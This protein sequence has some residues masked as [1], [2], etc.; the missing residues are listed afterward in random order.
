M[1]HS[2]SASYLRSH[3]KRSGLTLK[4]VA[5]LL[6]YSHGGEISR[7]ERLSSF[8][9]FKIALRY[10]ALYRT[11]VSVLFPGLFEEAKKEVEGKLATLVECCNQSTARGREG[12]MIARKL[13]W[14]WEREN[15]ERTG[16][17]RPIEH[18]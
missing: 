12:S 14:A 15:Q 13:E 18:G 5:N 9:P 2:H 16:L 17:F 3:R 1:T 10:E 8:P 7:H 6:G 11:P 4:E